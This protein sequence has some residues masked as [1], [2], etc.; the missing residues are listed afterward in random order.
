MKSTNLTALVMTAI[1]ALIAAALVY[2]ARSSGPDDGAGGLVRAGTSNFQLVTHEGPVVVRVNGLAITRGDIDR[3]IAGMPENILDFPR[4]RVMQLVLDQLINNRLLLSA[5]LEQGLDADPEA[6]KLVAMYRAAIIAEA[7]MEQFTARVVTDVEIRSRYEET[8]G[9]A[10]LQREVR[11]RQILVESEVLAASL[12][13]ELVGGADFAALA[14]QH[15]IDPS[16]PAGGDLGY[17]SRSAIDPEFAEA[18]FTLDVGGVTPVPVETEFGWH[19]IK[20]EAFRDPDLPVFDEV[21]AEIRSALTNEVIITHLEDL[22]SA[23]VVV[24]AE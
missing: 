17:F 7:Y 19:V 9:N 14:A 4:D 16:G 22:K 11:A 3:T 21:R 23:A 10:A 24:Y 1:V 20:A 5:G 8:I 2:G 15:S 18:I 6:L 13:A 12:I